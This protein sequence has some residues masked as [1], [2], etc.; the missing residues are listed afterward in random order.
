MFTHSCFIKNT[1]DQLKDILVGLGYKEIKSISKYN[2]R[3]EY[4]YCSCGKFSEE[5]L[6]FCKSDKYAIYCQN[7]ETFIA[8]ASIRDDTDKNQWFASNYFDRNMRPDSFVKCLSEDYKDFF[9]DCPYTRNYDDYHKATVNEL[10]KF[11]TK[12]YIQNESTDQ[13]WSIRD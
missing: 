7:E 11:F 12:T 4:L 9:G 1:S 6:H 3:K 10:I 2:G 13:A 5:P 8:V